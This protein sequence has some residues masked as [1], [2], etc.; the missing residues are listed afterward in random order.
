[1]LVRDA[2]HQLA[3]FLVPILPYPFGEPRHGSAQFLAAG[4]PFDDRV[5]ARAALLPA[6][7]NPR[8]SNRP[9]CPPPPRPKR[10]VCVLSSASS[11]PNFASRSLTASSKALP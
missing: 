5:P 9:L 11:S 10:S 8:K 1:M 7:F 2:L 4:A 3:D 6:K